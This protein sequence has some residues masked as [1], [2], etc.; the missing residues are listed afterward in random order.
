MRCINY[1]PELLTPDQ[2]ISRIHGKVRYIQVLS[3]RTRRPIRSCRL[4]QDYHVA[5]AEFEPHAAGKQLIFFGI[6]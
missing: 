3:D 6:G 2:L 5:W 4:E 1:W